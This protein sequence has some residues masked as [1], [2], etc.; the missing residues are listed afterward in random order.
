MLDTP[1]GRQFACDLDWAHGQVELRIEGR[2]ACYCGCGLPDRVEFIVA[3][4]AVAIADPALVDAAILTLQRARRQL[5]GP[6]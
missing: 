6:P 5:W 4:H 3:G 2:T 1:E